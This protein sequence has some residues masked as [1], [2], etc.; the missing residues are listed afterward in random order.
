MLMIAALGTALASM[1]IWV[2][3]AHADWD[4][5]V[6]RSYPLGTCLAGS[7]GHVVKVGCNGQKWDIALAPGSKDRYLLIFET[8]GNCMTHT[9]KALTVASCELFNTVDYWEVLQLKD[10]EGRTVTRFVNPNNGGC[11]DANIAGGAVYVNAKCRPIP[12]QQDWKIG[13]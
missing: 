12:S 7:N 11:L 9:P 8:S 4:G 5:Y 1:A 2:S 10:A 3:P 6:I 13:F